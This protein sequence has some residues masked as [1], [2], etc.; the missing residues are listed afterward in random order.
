MGGKGREWEEGGMGM[1]GEGEEGGKGRRGGRGRGRGGEWQ[2]Q[3][4][5]V[6]PDFISRTTG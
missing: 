5:I 2:D 1:R 4:G 3:E 6:P